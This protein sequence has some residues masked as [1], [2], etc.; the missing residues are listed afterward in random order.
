MTHWGCGRHSAHRPSKCSWLWFRYH[1]LERT[2]RTPF[3]GHGLRHHSSGP[4]AA[5]NSNR[6]E[7]QCNSSMLFLGKTYE[8]VACCS[9]FKCVLTFQMFHCMFPLWRWG[10]MGQQT[11]DTKCYCYCRGCM[12][13]KHM[14]FI[15]NIFIFMMYSF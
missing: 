5:M 4:Q 1:T 8:N 15:C 11:Q 7:H 2:G 12:S 3:P 9:N 10:N 13:R 6:R 14:C